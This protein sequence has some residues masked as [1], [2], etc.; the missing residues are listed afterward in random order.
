[1]NNLHFKIKI[2]FLFL[3]IMSSKILP[4]QDVT[5]KY[6]I[7]ESKLVAEDG[8]PVSGAVISSQEGAIETLSSE[9]GTFQ[10][11]VP[12][13]GE[14]L[15]EANGYE[16]KSI[17][18]DPV[19]NPV[20][21]IILKATPF[22]MGNGDRVNLLYG[23][24]FNRFVAGAIKV[25]N[26]E[27]LLEYDNIHWVQDAIGGRTPGLIRGLNLRGLGNA[28]VVIDG[29]VRSSLSYISIDEVEQITVLKDVNAGMLYGVLGNNGVIQITTKHGQPQK[30]KIDFKVE[31]GFSTPISLPKYLG[32]ADYMEL[33]NEALVNDGL[34]PLYTQA[35]IDGTRD[36]TNPMKYPD[37]DY[38]N[39]TFLKNSKPYTR[40]QAEFSGGNNS[41]Q[42]CINAGLLHSG[43]LMNLGE[44]ENGNSDR[45][46]MRA[47]VNFAI[48]NFIQSSIGIIT[49]FDIQRTPRGNFW[50]DA[51]TLRPN[52][53][54]PLIDTSAVS[55]KA[56]LNGSKVINGKYV[57]GGTT[58][59]QNNVWGNLFRAGYQRNI[60][61]TVQ[62][63]NELVVDLKSLAKG[64]SFKTHFS[65][66]L[67]LSMISSQNDLYAVY[68]PTWLIGSNNQDSLIL[69]KIGKDVTYGTQSLSGQ[70]SVRS[71]NIYGVLDYTRL[72]GKKHALSLSLIPFAD[73][74]E[75]TLTLLP[76][77][78]I[79][80]GTR[81]NY[82]YNNKYIIDFSSAISAS[83]KLAEGNRT[84]FSPSVAVGW[85]ISDENFLKSSSII[86]YLKLRASAGI[87]NTDMNI[88]N[89]YLYEGSW[90]SGS[91]FNWYDGL[92]TNTA[93]VINNVENMELFYEK[94]KDINLGVEAVLFNKSLWLDVN[95]FQESIT[96]QITRRTNTYPGYLGGYFPYENY[97]NKE[98]KGIEL[99]VTLRK[100]IGDFN[101]DTGIN[102]THVRS[103]VMKLDERWEDDYQYRVGKPADAIFGLVSSGLFLDSQDITDNAVQSFGTV[104]PGDI[105]YA[106]QNSDGI[107]NS[108]DEVMIGNGTPRF[109]GGLNIRVNYKNLTLFTLLSGTSNSERY[110]NNNYYW[111]YGTNKYSEIVSDR[112][113]SETASTATYPRLSSSSN[114]NNFRNS[115][116]WLYDNSY[117]SLDRLQLSYDLSQSLSSKL[118]MKKFGLFI[119]ATNV[120]L[121]SKNRDKMQLNVGSEP[122]YRTYLIGLKASF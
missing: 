96:D 65:Y 29:V 35:V 47:H 89:Y 77:K 33:Y 2:A 106:D 41:A 7:V 43:T 104:K 76:D 122:Q 121:I 75:E 46:H 40:Y 110:Y 48:T 113:T 36:G 50:S 84:A 28:L 18:I 62:F 17:I 85:I 42:Y 108:N 55:N 26:P 98:Y 20:Q 90:I 51:S 107:I 58:L 16:T 44:G 15:I 95:I 24:S 92:R 8:S 81:A 4:A 52:L 10:I 86:D 45:L 119:K 112:W 60:N 82:V 57:L 66:I 13:S 59:Y 31:Q 14:L 93:S 115:T 87:M 23:N 99:D 61:R 97:N 5:P 64:L 11:K 25:I 94:R 30:R 68:Q 91:S 37:V 67:D 116:Y 1:M 114:S 105:K 3:G 34:T 39:S 6:M 111:V 72:F 109:S 38:L 103:E 78:H 118:M 49:L 88:S 100:S 53:Y 56:V 9:D 32:S 73:R 79:H 21:A 27:E 70:T 117:I 83:P 54:P 12:V 19:F 69:N 63:D 101:F 74:T 102:I 80:L 120:A 71:L 22:S